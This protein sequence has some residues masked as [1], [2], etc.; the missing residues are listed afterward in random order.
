MLDKLISAYNSNKPDE[1][2]PVL[3]DNDELR[4]LII[5]T[6]C[7]IANEEILD[8]ELINRRRKKIN[9]ELL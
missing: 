2:I 4:N 6:K 8:Y 5:Y 3:F 9:V 1:S 7:G